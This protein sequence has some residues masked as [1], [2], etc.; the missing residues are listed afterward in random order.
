MA[1]KYSNELLQTRLEVQEQSLKY[2]SE[3]IHDN[4]LQVLSLIK[5]QL[6]SIKNSEEPLI[7][8]SAIN[9]LEILGKAIADLR[10]MSHTMNG[11]FVDNIGLVAALK[12]DISYIESTKQIAC[13]LKIEGDPITLG[14]GEELLIFRIMQ[15]AVANALK[16]ASATQIEV[17]LRYTHRCFEAI[18]QDNGIGFEI[19]NTAVNGLGLGNMELRAKLINANLLVTSVPNEGTCVKLQLNLGPA[20]T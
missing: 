14:A 19:D 15:E 18:V 11:H 1:N 17:M 7:K 10:N 20:I 3:E 16:H 2:F 9:S 12:K 13:R 6:F 8:E 5:M 4:I